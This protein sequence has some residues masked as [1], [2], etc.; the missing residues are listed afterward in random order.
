M[1]IAL[2]TAAGTGIRMHQDIPKQF[3]HVDNKP[4]IIHTMEVFQNHP[5][6]DIILVVTLDSWKEVL[7]AYA[8]QF[9]ISKLKWVVSGG[10]T[11]QDSIK[12]G[13]D[14]LKKEYPNKNINVMIHDGN[15]PLVSSEIISGNLA[16]FA[17]YGNAVAVIPCTEVVFESDNGISSNISTEREK[18]FRT[19]TPHTYKLNDLLWAHDEAKKRGI[20]G[21]AASCMLMKELGKETFFSKGSEE[22][23]KITTL[24]DLRIFK[25]LLHTK[26]DDWIKG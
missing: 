6:I 1:N 24:D 4:V 23:I 19:Q 20:K 2:L 12:N 10:E 18:L 7:W 15:R 5:S 14:K 21:T 25:A 16:V 3:I 11:G 22:N 17:K 8:K 13:L 9:N 26:Q